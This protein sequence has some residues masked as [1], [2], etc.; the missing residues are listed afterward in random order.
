MKTFRLF[1][2][3]SIGFAALTL[4]IVA[5]LPAHAQTDTAASAT[6][7]QKAEPLTLDELKILTARIA[8]YPDDLVA[9]CI[10]ASL[11][12]LQIVQAERFL[13]R[14]KTS[15]DLEPSEKWDGSVISLL[16][17]PSV[18][19]MMND[20]LDWTEQL[21]DATANQQKDVLVAIQQLRDE[22]VAKG[23]LKSGKQVQ[24]VHEKDKVII[25]SPDQKTVYVPTYPPEM[26]YDPGYVA[27]GP[28]IVYE[29]FPSYYYPTA[30]Y[31]AGFV[32]GAAF[33]A[34]VDWND[35][36]TWG[37]NVDVDVDIGDRINFDFDK[38]DIN[39]IDIDKL[40][41]V[42]F[43]NVDRSR[44]DLSN[45]NFDP[46]KLR[47]NLKSKDF[48]DIGR[49]AK[50]RV[51]A[52]NI[53]GFQARAHDLKGK[54]VRKSV[55]EGLKD[56]PTAKLPK[57]GTKGADATRV[58][59]QLKKA[60]P[61]ASRPAARQVT[62]KVTSKKRPA[63]MADSRPRMPSAIGNRQPGRI[64]MNHSSRGFESRGGGLRGGG[65]RGG[66]MRI[67]RR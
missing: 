34:V 55:A 65:A 59:E 46:D 26:L 33:A 39:N 49:K 14:K 31:W 12:P 64:A 32:T 42:D 25:K 7:E 22:A 58:G 38:I 28:P 24:V 10:A 6:T 47:D 67:H 1:G 50:D 52:D 17:Y 41:N 61:A 66:G 3:R 48:N 16:N 15:A 40:K 44:I 18:V 20:D 23:V 60:K 9:L 27:A 11:Y 43:R 37:G 19:K 56:R 13:E 21:G 30:P 2:S 35:W 8:L 45:V 36:G 53:N 4:A 51:G 29:P 62:Q 5:G 57:P 63:A 54:D